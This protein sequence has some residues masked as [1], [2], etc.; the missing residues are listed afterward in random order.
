M[1][2]PLS[3]AALAV[4][5][6]L[7]FVGDTSNRQ[8]AQTLRDYVAERF[9]ITQ[10]IHIRHS[11]LGLRFPDLVEAAQAQLDYRLRLANVPFVYRL[12]DELPEKI[13]KPRDENFEPAEVMITPAEEV[14]AATSVEEPITTSVSNATSN[15]TSNTTSNAT[16]NSTFET[17]QRV[18]PQYSVDLVYRNK[19][20]IWMDY[21]D[22]KATLSYSLE[23]IHQNDLPFYLTQAIY[24]NLMMLELEFYRKSGRFENYSST[25]Q[26]NFIAVEELGTTPEELKTQI[27]NHIDG[28]VRLILPFVQIT[29]NFLKFD[30]TKQRIPSAYLTNSTRMTNIYYLTSLAGIANQI[31]GVSLFHVH[32]EVVG[33]FVGEDKFGTAYSKHQQRLASIGYNSTE[34][35]G[36][37]ADA[38]MRA[39][40]LPKVSTENVN[41]QVDSAMKLNT[42]SGIIAV[43]DQLLASEQFDSQK[44]DNVTRLVDSILDE[45]SH[46]WSDHLKAIHAL[47][48]SA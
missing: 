9:A 43:L 41:L 32:K 4:W 18:K 10:D 35:L 34:F 14:I 20:G 19:L 38:V 13:K 30:I 2:F 29:V 3:I 42:I 17:P 27:D 47:Y 21:H 12:I 6:G 39:V 48:I 7:M 15:T 24:D 28:L 26:V 44:F 46:D 25:L 33:E 8:N 45:T 16:F 1:L 31:Q 23:A 37:S 5:I 11:D 22:Y 36:E 40:K